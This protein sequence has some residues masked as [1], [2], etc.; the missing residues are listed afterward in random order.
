[1]GLANIKRCADSMKLES[2]VGMGTQLE[3]IIYLHSESEDET[4][5]EKA[6]RPEPS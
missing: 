3:I 2:K 5:A 1:M 4:N 6:K